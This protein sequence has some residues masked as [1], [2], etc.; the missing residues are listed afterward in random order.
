MVVI[1]QDLPGVVIDKWKKLMKNKVSK[2]LKIL[3]LFIKK[4]PY[5]SEKK[6]EIFHNNQ[7]F[8]EKLTTVSA[9]PPFTF[10]GD[11]LVN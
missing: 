10:V 11:F 1:L 3:T 9:F 2:T 5:K 4:K 7:F 8:F 6:N